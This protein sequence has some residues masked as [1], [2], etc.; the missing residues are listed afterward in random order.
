MYSSV[1][2][3]YKDKQAFVEPTVK[4]NHLLERCMLSRAFSFSFWHSVRGTPDAANRAMPGG[5]A[6]S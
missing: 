5:F 3:N 6:K 2:T 4:R 1:M